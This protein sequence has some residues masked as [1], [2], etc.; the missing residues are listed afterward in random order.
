ML[1]YIIRNGNVIDGTGAKAFLADVGIANGK[2]AI[3][4]EKIEEPAEREIEADGQYVTPGFVDIHRHADANIFLE[5]FGELEIRQG[6]TTIING[7]CGLSIV[8]CPEKHRKEI[9]DFLK[10]IIGEVKEKKFDDY[11]SYME[12][13]G[14]QKLPINL[15]MLIGNGTVRAAVKGYETG[16]LTKKELEEARTYIRTSLEAGALG[17]SLGI[18]YAPEYNYQLEDFVEVLQ[19][20]KD[21]KV[22][23]VTH[24]RG[25]GDIFKE[26]IEEVIE[27]ARRLGVP[28]HISH[29]KCIGRR[30]WGHGVNTV[31]GLIEDARKRGMDVTCDVYP[32]TAGS[33]QLI[34]ILPPEYLEGG[35]KEIV[36]RLEDKKKRRELTEILK[37][38][39][40]SFENLVSSIGWENIRVTTV[41]TEKNKKYI[42]KSIEEI[43]NIQNKNPYDCAYDLLIDENCNVAMVDFITSEEDIQRILKYPYTNVISDTVYPTGGVPHPRMYGTFPRIL[44]K[45]VREEK[46]LTIEEAVKKMT[47]LPISV[48]SI[49]NKGKL[50]EGMD[51][52]VLIFDLNKIHTNANY[53]NPRQLAA[54]FS[55]VF[56]NGTL[57]VEN[58]RYLG[59]NTGK[60]V[61]NNT[62]N[63]L[64]LQ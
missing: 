1:E 13:V 44:E 45:Y 15:G 35:F 61:K 54:G 6:L 47:S 25:E 21:F 33:T 59:T 58:D 16:K 31:L 2:I 40:T 46:V 30:N 10:P 34:Q 56:V 17:I 43:A 20:M 12:L 36:K 32:Y 9:L 38:P 23:L 39:S 52:D 24:I 8:P 37:T 22:P 51:A 28:L 18:V 27:I 55:Y 49:E 29:L 26:S 5:E 62:K 50:K 63:Q 48:Y 14:E 11:A 42:G 64:F 41:M 53:D 60:I 3:I 7:N 19:P 57:A 4:Q